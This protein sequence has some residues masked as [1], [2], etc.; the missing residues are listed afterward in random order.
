LRYYFA[1]VQP[2]ALPESN[3]GRETWCDDA[4]VIR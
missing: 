4:V 3:R 1:T 2:V